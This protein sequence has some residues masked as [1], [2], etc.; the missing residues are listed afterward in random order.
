MLTKA[1][2]DI[3]AK[4]PSA[5]VG[6]LTDEDVVLKSDI[7]RLRESEERWNRANRWLTFLAVAVGAVLGAAGFLAAQNAALKS[8]SAQP[9]QRRRGQIAERLS[10]LSDQQYREDVAVAGST[11][12]K[13]QEAAVEA[14]LEQAKLNNANLELQATIERERTARVQLLKTLAY[15][16]LNMSE[17]GAIRRATYAYRKVPLDILY[18][19][20]GDPEVGHFTASIQMAFDIW[21]PNIFP[22][23]YFAQRGLTV[24]YD[25]N[26]PQASQA[27]QHFLDALNHHGFRVNGP[28]PSCRG[29]QRSCL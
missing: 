8:S 28:F 5:E 11:A 14:T 13:A 16:S 27:A 6:S 15:R 18:C 1:R 3:A 29:I 12:S 20:T 2:L 21:K 25:P 7:E 19:A 10:M 24:E 22:I 4:A 17:L 23:S 26:D 9:L